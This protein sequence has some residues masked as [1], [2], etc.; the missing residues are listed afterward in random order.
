MGRWSFRYG[1]HTHVAYL[2]VYYQVHVIDH[3]HVVGV[4]PAFVVPLESRIRPMTTQEV[5]AVGLT[6]SR[7]AKVDSGVQRLQMFLK[8]SDFLLDELPVHRYLTDMLKMGA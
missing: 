2:E 5:L 4:A 3:V 8:S 7:R 1:Y 6:L